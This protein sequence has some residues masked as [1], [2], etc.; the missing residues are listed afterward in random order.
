MKG[1]G[2]NER[3]LEKSFEKFFKNSLDRLCKIYYNKNVKSQ[4]EERL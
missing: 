3:G 1:I 4:E 2:K